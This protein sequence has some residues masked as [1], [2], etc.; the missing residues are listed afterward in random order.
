MSEHYHDPSDVR[1]LKEMR[2]LAPKDYE[3]WFALNAIVGRE[4][5]AIPRKYR[6]L[7][8]IAVSVTTQC[9]YCI[10]AHVKGAKAAGA[11]KEEVA[12]ASLVAAALRAGGAAMHGTL[13]M[14]FFDLPEPVR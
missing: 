13:A 3:A 8:A 6:E 9:P 7:I 4:D 5:G 11:S 12:E 14:K 1:L 2:K 10:E